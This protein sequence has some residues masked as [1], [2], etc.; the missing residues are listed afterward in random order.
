M[1]FSEAIP[2]KPFQRSHFSTDVVKGTALPCLVLPCLVSYRI[3]L[4]PPLPTAPHCTYH[5]GT[6]ATQTE[7]LIT[8][9]KRSQERVP[10]TVYRMSCRKSQVM[11]GSRP[12]IFAH[13]I[14]NNY[15]IHVRKDGKSESSCVRACVHACVHVSV[16]HYLL[17]KLFSLLIVLSK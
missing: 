8:S 13:V 6:E 11:Y 16:E 12:P 7:P 4:E 9:M 14:Y 1:H 10:R 2:A 15:C 3:A 17:I 5:A